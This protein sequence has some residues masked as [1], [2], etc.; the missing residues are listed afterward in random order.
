MDY[1]KVADSLLISARER[2]NAVRYAIKKWQ[3]ID[4]VVMPDS[5]F[6][7]ASRKHE[8]G[9]IV[10]GTIIQQDGKKIMILQPK[11]SP[12]KTPVGKRGVAPSPMLLRIKRAADFHTHFK[13]KGPSQQ[14]IEYTNTLTFI[15]ELIIR[16]KGK[17]AK[18]YF[19]A[20]F[21]TNLLGHRPPGRFGKIIK[22]TILSVARVQE[23]LR[24]KRRR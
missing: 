17:S 15:P 18:I 11:K 10:K 3:D 7:L 9:G 13:R 14:D 20:D 19:P 5:V 8:V 22:P 24:R 21:K 4:E 12:H 23:L 1:K 2:Q 6:E 16:R